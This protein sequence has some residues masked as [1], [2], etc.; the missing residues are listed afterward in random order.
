MTYDGFKLLNI[1]FYTL[2]VY[3]CMSPTDNPISNNHFSVLEIQV[4]WP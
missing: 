1:E 4:M 2:Y 3:I